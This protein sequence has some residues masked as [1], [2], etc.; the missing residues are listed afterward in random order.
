MTRYGDPT[1]RPGRKVAR[2]G[3]NTILCPMLILA[4]IA[5]LSACNLHPISRSLTRY[6]YMDTAGRVVIQMEFKDA[7]S[8]SEGLAA[9]EVDGKW[10]YIDRNGQMVIQPQ[11]NNARAFKNGMALVEVSPDNWRYI[12]RTGKIAIG[13][14]FKWGIRA[15]DF[16]EGLAAV[17]IEDRS[18][19]E[20][21]PS[22]QQNVRERYNDSNSYI[23]PQFCGRWGFIGPTGAFN[24][25]PQFI[26]AFSF[27]EGLAAVR[28][29]DPNVQNK[30]QWLYGYI[31]RTGAIAIAPQFEAAFDFSDGIACV[32]IDGRKG[33]IDKTGKRLTEETFDDAKDFHEGLAQVKIGDR[34]GYI[35]KTG[36]IAI[37]AELT[38]AG[39]FSEGLAAARRSG[40]LGGYID[41]TGTMVISEQFGVAWAFSDGLARVKIGDGRGLF[42]NWG[43]IDKSGKVVISRTLKAGWPFSEG[44]ALVGNGGLL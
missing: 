14:A 19:F 43:Y 39:R 38:M 21:L 37:P 15:R 3:I 24:I 28:V 7:R 17:Y 1:V 41:R 33:F 20:C 18:R 4:L 25:E 44:L 26:E 27:S 31:D 5:S 22:V 34:W 35:D 23:S 10:G 16:S 13:V 36:K 12:D 8:F 30:R 32:V 2:S 11:F 40:I 42:D 29:Q 6:G 9:V